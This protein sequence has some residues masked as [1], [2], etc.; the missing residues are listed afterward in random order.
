MLGVFSGGSEYLANFKE[1][2]QVTMDFT[3]EYLPKLLELSAYHFR[4][5]VE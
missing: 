5:C 2:S 3:F 1:K 4:Q